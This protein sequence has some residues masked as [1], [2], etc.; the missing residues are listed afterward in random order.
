MEQFKAAAA[1]IKAKVEY[2][3]NDSGS[4]A[5]LFLKVM[6]QA[7]TVVNKIEPVK[8]DKPLEIFYYVP[9]EDD[10]VLDAV[11]DCICL[12]W[13]ENN[14][15]VR[16]YDYPM[17]D[18]HALFGRDISILPLKWASIPTKIQ[19]DELQLLGINCVTT[20]MRRQLCLRG[21]LIWKNGQCIR[22]TKFP[23]SWR[24]WATMA[25]LAEQIS[26]ADILQLGYPR[27]L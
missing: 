16:K 14:Q 13:L 8:S 9:L 15:S 11:K 27:W 3:K 20:Y 26:Y 7:F 17:T 12:T 25:V 5:G 23:P 19:E 18:R 4:E 2:I 6:E 1:E 10:H 22:S 24:D 21:N